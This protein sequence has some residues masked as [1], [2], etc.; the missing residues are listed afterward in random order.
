MFLVS[1]WSLWFY[2]CL[3]LK[4]VFFLFWFLIG[5]VGFHFFIYLFGFYVI[6]I[7]LFFLMPKLKLCFSC[8]TGTQSSTGTPLF[9]LVLNTEPFRIVPAIPSENIFRLGIFSYSPLY[10]FIFFLKVT[11]KIPKQ[12]FIDDVKGES[13]ER[14]IEQ[15]SLVLGKESS[16]TIGKDEELTRDFAVHEVKIITFAGCNSLSL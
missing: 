5:F 2:C 6:F 11:T 4:G 8:S 7:F 16:R 1:L 9:C 15:I 14:K 3:S 13:Q 12:K 10:F